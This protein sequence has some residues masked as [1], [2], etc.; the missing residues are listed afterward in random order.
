MKL[1]TCSKCGENK[2]DADFWRRGG[3][4]GGRR[5]RCTLCMGVPP[6]PEVVEVRLITCAESLDG[7]TL[8]ELLDRVRRWAEEGMLEREGARRDACYGLVDALDRVMAMVEG[9]RDN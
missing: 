7:A 2:P 5:S 9:D 4:R 3:M 6:P 1:K 8:T